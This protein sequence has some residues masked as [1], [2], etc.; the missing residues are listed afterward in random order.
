MLRLSSAS[1]R[2]LDEAVAHLLSAE[3][4]HARGEDEARVH[5]DRALEIGTHSQPVI[6]FMARMSEAH[7]SLDGGRD[8]DG[9]RALAAALELGREPQLRQ[10]ARVDRRRM[11]RLGARAARTV[12]R[13]STRATRPAD[14]RARAGRPAGRRRGVALAHQ[15]FTLGRFE[16]RETTRRSSLLSQGPAQA[17]GPPQDVDR[18]RRA[19]GARGSRDGRALA[20]CRRR[21]RPH[22]VG[23]RAPP[24]ARIVGPRAARS[25][26]QEGQA[27]PRSAT[28]AG[29]TSGRSSAC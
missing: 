23:Q 6:Q 9:L 20:G 2:P 13:W 24:P 28:P 5:L 15:I 29:S 16:L 8:A 12:S 1:G 3:V 14:A 25:L 4:R 7:L 27:E 19:R 21:C 18:L 26:R 11:A 10:L 22:G 17:A